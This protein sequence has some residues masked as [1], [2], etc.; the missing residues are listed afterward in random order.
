MARQGLT[1]QTVPDDAYDATT[2]N[3]STEVPTKNA[4]RDKIES[5]GGGGTVTNTGGSL[6][7]NS[8]ILG[9]GSNDIKAAP[10]ISTNGSGAMYL[11]TAGTAIGALTMANATSGSVTIQTVSGALGTCN[12]LLPAVSDTFVGKATADVL[13]NKDLTSG[14]NTFPTFNQNT[15]GTAANVTGIVAISNGGTG[16]ATKNFIDLTSTQSVGGQK[17]FASGSLSLAGI[18]SGNIVLNATAV[19]GTGNVITL[20][21]ATDTLVGKSTTDTLT[22]K[23]LTSGTNT[24]PTFNQNTTGSAAKLTTARN[25]AIGGSTGLFS[26]GNTFDGSAAISLTLQGTLDVAYGGTGAT[27]ASAA[28]TNLGLG[29]VDNTSDA[30]K[31]LSF[32]QVA[33]PVGSIYTNKTN[34]TNPATLFGFGTWTALAGRV[35]VGKAA[36]GTFGTAGATPGAETL[37][38]TAQNYRFGTWRSESV[39]TG[40]E[41]STFFNSGASLGI[42]TDYTTNTNTAISLVQPSLVAYMWERTA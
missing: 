3:G 31:Q 38:L 23:N 26:A 4:I 32:L 18:T 28:R 7:L 21:V 5:M 6:T 14:T 30:T 25:I 10:N 20:P 17:T 42:K 8:V 13:S 11:G 15:T 27:S 2:W 19:T 16:S 41:L 33:Y 40:N 36:S 39:T 12:W 34:S 24:F 22:N 37:V 35:I 9:A 29:N 1:P